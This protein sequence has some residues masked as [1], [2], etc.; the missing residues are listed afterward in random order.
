MNTTIAPEHLAA[1]AVLA[2][3]RASPDRSVGL[4]RGVGQAAAGTVFVAV[5]LGVVVLS[6]IAG[7]M[8]KVAAL[9]RDFLSLAGTM[10]SVLLTIVV[11]IVGAGVLLIH[12]H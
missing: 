8:S 2:A 3:H 11:V 1:I 10:A 5:V 7:A 4:A 12:H 6:A 9:I